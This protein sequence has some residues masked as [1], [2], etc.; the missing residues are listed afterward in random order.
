MAKY[1]VDQQRECGM[2]RTRGETERETNKDKRKEAKQ[3]KKN[4]SILFGIFG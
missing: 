3:A 1:N 2:D 4:L